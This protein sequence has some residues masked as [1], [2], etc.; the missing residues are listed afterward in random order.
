M[1][2]VL[3][4]VSDTP[5]HLGHVLNINKNKTINENHYMLYCINATCTAYLGVSTSIFEV[6]MNPKGFI[7]LFVCL[8]NYIVRSQKQK[9]SS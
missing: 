2:Y 6:E 4:L 7:Y 1:P 5:K 8:G 9:I 3:L